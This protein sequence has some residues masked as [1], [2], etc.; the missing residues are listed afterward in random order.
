MNKTTD[1]I[2]N[3]FTNSDSLYL[4]NYFCKTHQKYYER[5]QNKSDSC[6]GCGIKVFLLNNG[7][8]LSNKYENLKGTKP[9]TRLRCEIN[10]VINSRLISIQS[11]AAKI[12]EMIEK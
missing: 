3:S 1:P 9:H 2:N 6:N 7:N 12:N 11:G 8:H 5:L 4:K 10:Q